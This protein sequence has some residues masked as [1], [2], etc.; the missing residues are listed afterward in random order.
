M[1]GGDNR[2]EST[3]RIVGCPN[4]SRAE[5]FVEFQATGTEAVF[6]V[7]ARHFVNQDT[8]VFSDGRPLCRLFTPAEGGYWV[9]SPPRPANT[10]S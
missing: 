1:D 2:S 9:I 8:Q 4:D 5:R 7:T 3:Y 10:Q 6:L